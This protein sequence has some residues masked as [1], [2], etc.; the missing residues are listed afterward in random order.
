VSARNAL[1]KLPINYR[2]N[3][4]NGNRHGNVDSA[5][6]MA[7]PLR[8]FIWFIWLMR[9]VPVPGAD[10]WTKPIRIS[11]KSTYIGSFSVYIH[12]RHLL[13]YSARLLT[14]AVCGNSVL[15]QNWR[16]YLLDAVCVR[17]AT[18]LSATRSWQFHYLWPGPT[19]SKVPRKILGRF[20]ILGKS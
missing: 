4:S 18:G 10:L 3:N 20:H 14:W 16:R 13:L 9:T 6:I 19:F 17:D 2:D 5:V 15:Q 11:R 7:E 1:L 8:E 12:H